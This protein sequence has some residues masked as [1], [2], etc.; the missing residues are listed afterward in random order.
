MV[1]RLRKIFYDTTNLADII[2][3]SISHLHVDWDI[4]KVIDR[5]SDRFGR[6]IREAMNVAVWNSLPILA[7][8]LKSIAS[9]RTLLKS[10][11]LSD[12]LYILWCLANLSLFHVLGP[13]SEQF[14]LPLGLADVISAALCHVSM[15]FYVGK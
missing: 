9:F 15:F 3:I 8:N 13:M 1:T 11:D 10:C 12:F 7:D 2:D 4:V 6:Q 14:M 5:E